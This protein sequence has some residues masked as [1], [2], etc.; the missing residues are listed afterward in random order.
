LLPDL[1]IAGFL[2]TVELEGM[3][4]GTRDSSLEVGIGAEPTREAAVILVGSIPEWKRLASRDLYNPAS[5]GKRDQE[6]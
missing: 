2:A 3:Q 1:L 6:A 5:T 4:M